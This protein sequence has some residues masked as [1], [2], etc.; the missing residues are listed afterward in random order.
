[1]NKPSSD[2]YEFVYPNYSLSKINY[3]EKG[4]FDNFE[5]TSSG[6]NKNFQQYF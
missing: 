4:F 1:M 6:N 3:F 2:R 5:F